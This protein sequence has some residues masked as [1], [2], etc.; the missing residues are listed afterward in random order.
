MRM[1]NKYQR[2]HIFN[3]S[4]RISSMLRATY[5]HSGV[6][7]I[8]TELTIAY[9]HKPYT[10]ECGTSCRIRGEDAALRCCKYASRATWECITLCTKHSDRV[11]GERNRKKEKKL[12]I[13]A[14]LGYH[15]SGLRFRF[16]DYQPR[17]CAMLCACDKNLQL[18]C[19]GNFADMQG[20]Y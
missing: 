1:R 6:A 8:G 17:N 2:K 10:A 11:T 14:V 13:E 12:S 4:Q 20:S 9:I 18:V 5:G 3:R 15:R 19:V 7:T 16:R